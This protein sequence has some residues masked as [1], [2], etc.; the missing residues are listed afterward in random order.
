MLG[1][2]M[3]RIARG[4]VILAVCFAGATSLYAQSSPPKASD[5][6]HGLAIAPPGGAP[7]QLDLPAAMQA[8]HIPSVSAAVIERGRLDWARAFGTGATADTLYQAASL[9][10]LVTAVAALRL[11]EQGRLALDRNVNDE[12]TAWRLPDSALTRGHPVTL[13]GLLSMTGGVGVP[14]YIGYAPGQPLPNL[15]RFS[16]ARR[17]RTRRRSGSNTSLGPAMPILG[18]ATKSCRH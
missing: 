7:R 12:L 18:A 13:R 3:P 16:M 6:E 10:K 5:I 11:V 17:P 15:F 14:G 2:S 9:S 8:L 1:F 4:A